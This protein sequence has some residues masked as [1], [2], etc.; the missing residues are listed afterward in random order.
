[1]PSL[2]IMCY[3]NPQNQKWIILFW[4]IRQWDPI[5]NPHL[6]HSRW[7]PMLLVTFYKLIVQPYCG[8]HQLPML[9]NMERLSRYS[10]T[11]FTFMNSI[12]GAGST[13]SV[14]KVEKNHQ[15]HLVTYTKSYNRSLPARCKH[16]YNSGTGD[17][18]VAN[19]FVKAGFKSC[20][21]WQT[22]KLTQLI[23]LD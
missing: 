17:I 4:T 3:Q 16:W 2:D 5:D 9:S 19:H 10:T 22:P 15:S 11:S 23:R 1:M 13:I 12:H 21:I 18:E 14:T 6:K 7:F 20:S 8:M